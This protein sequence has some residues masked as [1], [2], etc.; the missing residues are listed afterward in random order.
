MSGSPF[1]QQG[2]PSESNY[3]SDPYA[4]SHQPNQFGEQHDQAYRQ[5]PSGQ[6]PGKVQGIAVMVLVGG[7]LSLLVGVGFAVSCIMLAWP[8][9]YYAFVLGIMA[10]VK[11]SQ[12]LGKDDYLQSPPKAIAIMMIINIVNFDVT[13]LV[14]GILVLVFLS[15]PEVEQY[16]QGGQ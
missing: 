8:G 13:N 2:S 11:G 16:Y 6:K 7:I 4:G 1:D 10:I 5:V 14:L 3:P 9:T 12:L 15:D